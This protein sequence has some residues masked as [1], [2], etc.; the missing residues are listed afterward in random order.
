MREWRKSH[1][2]TPEQRHKS[3]ARA[4]ANVYERRGTLVKA[5]CEVCGSD[6]TEKHHDD[7][8]K[9]LEVRWL[10]RQHHLEHHRA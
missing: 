9:P 6:K 1:P 7:Y 4:Y 10:C 8:D 3:N 5:P 2:L